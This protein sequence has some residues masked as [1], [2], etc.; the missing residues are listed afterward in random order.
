M[1]SVT[2]YSSLSHNEGHKSRLIVYKLSQ[3]LPL[4]IVNGKSATDTNSVKKGLTIYN[5][6]ETDPCVC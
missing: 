4:F 3:C 1:S 2:M 6:F 5:T